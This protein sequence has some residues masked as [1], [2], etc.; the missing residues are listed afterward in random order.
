MDSLPQNSSRFDATTFLSLQLNKN[1]NLSDLSNSLL[2]QKILNQE[3]LKVLIDTK[4]NHFSSV[5]P[6]INNFHQITNNSASKISLVSIQAQELKTKLDASLSEINDTILY[7]NQI[8][9]TKKALSSFV[10]IERILQRLERTASSTTP[11]SHPLIHTSDTIKELGRAAADLTKLKYLAI[12]YKKY[13][14]I[15]KSSDRIN[16]VNLKIISKLD[17]LFLDIL[18]EW[19]SVAPEYHEH[20]LLTTETAHDVDK[21]QDILDTFTQ[22]LWAYHLLEKADQAESLIRKS[23]IGPKIK[24]AIEKVGLKKGEITVDTLTF[25]KILEGILSDLIIF[26]QPLQHLVNTHLINTNI[27]IA[28]FSAWAEFAF[29][30]LSSMPTLFVPGIPHRFQANYSKAE[31]FVSRFLDSVCIFEDSIERLCN[32]DIYIE[33]WKKWH[34]PAYFAIRQR[35]IVER[36]TKK[37]VTN[38]EYNTENK[39]L[40]ESILGE[41]WDK[42]TFID[43]LSYRWW[44]LTLQIIQHYNS[45]TENAMNQFNKSF[46]ESKNQTAQLFKKES[47]IIKS[48]KPLILLINDI[49][50][51]ISSFNNLFKFSIIPMILGTEDKDFETP[52]LHP[53]SNLKQNLVINTE[54]KDTQLSK[55]LQQSADFVNSMLTKNID[56]GINILV[57]FTF[58]LCKEHATQIKQIPSMYRHT[59]RKM[60]NKCSDFV[61]VI[62]QPL[63][64][65]YNLATMESGTD[66][67][68]NEQ[69]LLYRDS[70]Q[71]ANQSQNQVCSTKMISKSKDN[72]FM[73]FHITTI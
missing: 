53:S 31:E 54:S 27:D 33:W 51:V 64:I 41:I 45:Y 40:V 29:I 21:T 46:A 2:T 47:I 44:K 61:G 60:P 70:E 48:T 9:E 6:K 20:N 32:S 30:T 18:N 58:A 37:M 28:V 71:V 68:M 17:Q 16:S 69:T 15:S 50:G 14:F 25:S 12:R 67:L 26:V 43:L 1:S 35:N 3:K 11:D 39:L 55:I 57:E 36:I 65:I 24:K 38:E 8:N 56:N 34:L 62:F 42:N 59:N 66:K 49:N 10:Q 63:E 23:L 4:Y 73:M 52:D 7:K 72:Y 22:A 13:P 5:S 19:I